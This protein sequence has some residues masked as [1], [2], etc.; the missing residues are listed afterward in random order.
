MKR[1]KRLVSVILCLGMLLGSMPA[2]FAETETVDSGLG[3]VEGAGQQ[4]QAKAGMEE[5]VKEGLIAHLKLD[6]DVTDETGVGTPVLQGGATYEEGISGQAI[7]FDGARGKT[8]SN[9]I[10]LADRADLKF[11]KDSA[12]TAGIWF[13]TEDK[14]S[15]SNIMGSKSWDRA[16]NPGWCIAI[17]S[18]D[19]GRIRF[20]PV[21]KEDG[22]NE[23]VYKA[24]ADSGIFDGSGWVYLVVTRDENGDGKIYIDGKAV[25]A[26]NAS[27]SSSPNADTD[28]A[29]CIGADYLGQY[30]PGNCVAFDDVRIWNRAL[31]AEEIAYVYATTPELSKVTISGG[32]Q[33]DLSNGQEKQVTLTVKATQKV[34]GEVVPQDQVT[35][36]CTAEG[37]TVAPQGN[38]ATAV[39]TVA[40]D[41]APQT[42][43]IEASCR[44]VTGSATLEIVKDTAPA[45]AKIIGK[46][47]VLK[48]P[49]GTQESYRV[50]FY[51]QY[52]MVLESVSDHTWS[53]E[54]NTSG[55]SIEGN[56]TD[57]TV[58]VKVPAEAAADSGF[59]LKM[60]GAGQTVTQEVR[61]VSKG[62][63]PAD[64]AGKI[65]NKLSFEG[66]TMVDS[67]GTIVPEVIGGLSYQEGVQGQAG[68]FTDGNYIDLGKYDLA[69][70]TITMAF[71]S[72]SFTG[73]QDPAILANKDWNKADEQGFLFAYCYNTQDK[74][75]SRVGNG[76]A[77]E[78]VDV[79]YQQGTWMTLGFTLEQEAYCIYL[80]G[81]LVERRALSDWPANWMTSGTYSLKLGNDGTG[82]Y[83]F[84]SDED[85]KYQFLVDNFTIFDSILSQQEMEEVAVVNTDQTLPEEVIV[86]PLADVL[87][88]DFT[89][90]TPAD[91]SRY[92]T[93]YTQAAGATVGRDGSLERNV[94]SLSGE[95]NTQVAYKVSS[96]QM[97]KT[98]QTFS[99]ETAFLV[100][101]KK[102]Q[103]IAGNTE[104]AGMSYE[105][106]GNGRVELWLWSSA[107]NG[108]F[109]V[110]GVKP[111]FE[112]ETGQYYH[113]MT[114]YDGATLKIYLNGTEVYSQA[115]EMTVVHPAD[116]TGVSFSI[117]GDPRANYN[118]CQIPLNGKVA[119]LGLY[120]SALS[121]KQVGEVYREFQSGERLTAVGIEMEGANTVAANLGTTHPY[122][123]NFLAKNGKYVQPSDRE[124]IRWTLENAPAGVRIQSGAEGTDAVEILV[125]TTVAQGA[126]FTVKA[127]YTGVQPPW[128]AQ[129]TVQVTNDGTGDNIKIAVLGDF[130]LKST[131]SSSVTNNME[132][133]LRNYKEKGVDV[134]LVPGDMTDDASAAGYE[135]MWAVFDKVWP[136]RESRPP[137]ISCMGNHDYW[138]GR[139]QG[140][141]NDLEAAQ[142]LYMEQMGVD[143]L[144]THDVVKGY[145][146]ISISPEDDSTHGLFTQESV[147]YLKAE[148]AKA[149]AEDPQ[150]PVFVMAHQHVRKKQADGTETPTV[151]LSDEWGNSALYEAMEPY[152]Q[153]VFFSG[154]SH[155]PIDDERSIHQ[156]DFTS[157]GTSSMNY[158]ELESGK[159]GGTKPVGYNQRSQSLYVDVTPDQ[160]TVERWD[161]GKKM[162]SRPNWVIEEPAS[163]D[164]FAYTNEKRI[165][166]RKAPEFAADAEIQVSNRTDSTAKITLPAATHEDFVHSYR[167]EIID[168]T[169]PEVA[170]KNLLYF[171]DFCKSVP[172]MS[173]TV[174]Y[175][176]SGLWGSTEYK[177]NVYAIESFGKESV[178]LSVT[179][180]TEKGTIDP[181]DPKPAADVL[182]V[183]FDTGTAVDNSSFHTEL[184]PVTKSGGT[185]VSY[186]WDDTIQHMVMNCH[187]SA[188][189]APLNDTQMAKIKSQYSIEAVVKL[190]NVKKAQSIF[191]NT[192]SNGI[193]LEITSTGRLE[194]WA[195]IGS[196]QHKIGESEN[197]LL[198]AGK[199]YHLMGTYN[200]SQFNL[201]VNGQKVATKNA[202]GSISYAD[203]L[204]TYIGGDTDQNGNIQAPIMGQIA[205]ARLYSIGLNETQVANIYN[206]YYQTATAVYPEQ[207]EI[208]GPAIVMVP[209]EEA[210]VAEYMV[211]FTDEAGEHVTVTDPQQIQWSLEGA[212]DGVTIPQDSTGTTVQLSVT[213]DVASQTVTLKATYPVPN[214]EQTVLTAQKDISISKEALVYPV[215]AQVTG[216]ESVS[217]PQQETA[218]ADYTVIF[219]DEE[220]NTVTVVDPQSIQW[221]LEGAEA[222]VAIPPNSTGTTV[223][224]SV[225]KDASM[226]TVTL[227]AVYPVPNAEQTVLTAQKE[228]TVAEPPA[229]PVAKRV[230]ITGAAS[231]QGGN[232]TKTQQYTAKA[233]D[234]YGAEMV[235]PFEWNILSSTVDGVGLSADGLL[236]I[237]ANPS[238]GQVVL[239][240]AVKSNPDITAK[241]TVRIVG[242]STGGTG[243]G[244]GGSRQP[245]GS[246]SVSGGAVVVN[247]STEPAPSGRLEYIG[248][249]RDMPGTHWAG[250]SIQKLLDS[251]VI[252]GDTQGNMRPDEDITREETVKVLLLALN[253]FTHPE[254]GAVDANTSQW[255]KDYMLSAKEQ[256]IVQGD[257]HG[258]LNGK[259]VITR[260]DAMV[261][262]ARAIGA[263]NGT[264][265]MLSSFTDSSQIPEYAKPYVARLVEMG[266]VKGYTDGSIGADETITR[267]ELFTLIARI[268]K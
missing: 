55:A 197:Y 106:N 126:S 234:Q 124:N 62:V 232:A 202:S 118:G 192:Q 81:Q 82:A 140:K 170:V 261:M 158:L 208:S 207:A 167:V 72:I 205:L 193:S 180:T 116:A 243:G 184:I 153:V 34:G 100:N 241:M 236:Y 177:V 159:E 21:S 93:E 203:G 266:M 32:G 112:V 77:N 78:T 251:G 222:G 129:K 121:A 188:V 122:T 96:A 212:G 102:N 214:R 84:N 13:Q 75:R 145:H 242:Y 7:R 35:W 240:V 138:N 258:N 164:N 239:Q 89:D 44:G 19:N 76:N 191:A 46:H 206:D 230:E 74:F 36:S 105:M 265:G 148:L 244:G 194:M 225:T 235:E 29:F 98:S 150:K 57:N 199:Y 63:L 254:E 4:V 3:T 58:T 221:S 80:D 125:E 161:K 131:T 210:A 12:Y 185:E 94:L 169:H 42:V 52:G 9:R 66:N 15:D 183:T 37:V 166:A 231:I 255:A 59:T 226:Q 259:D 143:S 109:N 5:Q 168:L 253:R 165:A 11:T 163:K 178:P 128:V 218:T 157:I 209:T 173:D 175:S 70:K 123:L 110:N 104:K 190:D 92:N 25:S 64:L 90:G 249:F 174:S 22:N 23:Y 133:A 28:G 262:I 38:G 65:E 142:K 152:P 233:Y 16:S 8:N 88:V 132:T 20:A 79:K 252:T 71:Q 1:K 50:E 211:A 67:G 135:K 48:L 114:T 195:K 223:Q 181:S 263:D 237:N 87:D 2:C 176:L 101:G 216:P 85:S 107:Q 229:P 162:G 40:G 61:L 186:S 268:M 17:N 201:Y 30:G 155:A 136:D 86:H 18:S 134:I 41:A 151:Y 141:P 219:T 204:P 256:S 115:A 95:E 217:I 39:V 60:Q 26:P 99:F 27:I 139:F 267:A 47:A 228:I 137:I 69:G 189:K 260:M 146:F 149:V 103:T 227:K 245:S 224:L 54:D 119:R 215:E 198:E 120:S 111:G 130:Q 264:I 43:Q 160:I 113:A 31:S 68:L 196:T 33:V 24:G 49:N 257:E 172:N 127:T 187:D 6:G 248:G 154:H 220:G 51:N 213:K 250:S 108:Y 10:E 45:S 83:K 73:V 246:S 147:D 156:E 14:I 179:F 144:R 171:S 200:G 182:N 117:G 91:H 238:S 247:P 53:L 97:E 56:N